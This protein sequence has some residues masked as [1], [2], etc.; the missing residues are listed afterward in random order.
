ML[1][2]LFSRPSGLRPRPP[3]P[4]PLARV[5][6]ALAGMAATLLAAGAA[7]AALEAHGLSVH[8]PPPKV[9]LTVLIDGASSATVRVL[10]RVCAAAATC[11][12]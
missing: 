8:H 6:A 3:A 2:P 1:R 5:G 7:L 4:G 11:R 12:C 10:Y 9:V